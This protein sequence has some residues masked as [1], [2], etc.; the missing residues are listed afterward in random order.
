MRKNAGKENP[1]SAP[2]LF[3]VIIFAACA[4]AYWIWWAVK[5]RSER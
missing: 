5:Y 2:A 4:G 3:D 1:M